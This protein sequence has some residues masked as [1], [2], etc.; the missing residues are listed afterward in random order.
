MNP[1]AP[2]PAPGHS[3][4]PSGGAARGVGP[5]GVVPHADGRRPRTDGG[6]DGVGGCSV[7]S[8]QLEFPAAARPGRVASAGPGPIR[9][10]PSRLDRGGRRDAPRRSGP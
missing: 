10:D 9:S 7:S 3:V 2:H 1:G 6:Q 8:V 5:A 4:L